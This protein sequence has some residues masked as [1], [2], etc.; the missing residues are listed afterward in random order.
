MEVT[1]GDVP[2]AQLVL[3]AGRAPGQ[4]AAVVL[5]GRP[6][7]LHAGRVVQGLGLAVAGPLARVH[8]GLPTARHHVAS[9][10]GVGH[11]IHVW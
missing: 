4:R 10:P 6:G 5:A 3:K 2:A 9:H 11:L 8:A 7:L 1:E